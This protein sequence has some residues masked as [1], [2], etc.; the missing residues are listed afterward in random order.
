MEA[1]TYPEVSWVVWAERIETALTTLIEQL[2]RVSDELERMN[3]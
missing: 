2:E 3:R 1:K